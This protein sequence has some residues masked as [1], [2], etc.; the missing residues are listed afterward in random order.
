MKNS[1][2]IKRTAKRQ[3]PL[4]RPWLVDLEELIPDLEKVWASGKLSLGLYTEKLEAYARKTLGV[5]EAIA[6]SSCTSGIILVLKALEIK[7]KVIVPD[8]TFPATSHAVLWAGAKVKFC[9]ID[10]DD[11]TISPEALAEINDPEVEAVIPVNI[12]GLPPKISELEKICAKRGWKLIFDSAQGLGAE[13]KG[14]RCGGFGIAEVFSLSPSKVITSAE[15]GIITTNDSGLALKLR[16]LRDYGKG[17]DKADML[18]VGLSARMSEL[19]AVLG[20]HNFKHLDKLRLEREKLVKRYRKKL[21]GIKGLAFQEFGPER[22]SGYNYFVFRVT[23]EAGKTRDHLLEELIQA[24]IECKRYFYPPL[25]LLTAYKGLSNGG[26][27]NAELLSWETI[28]V[29]LY[30]GMK[31]QEQDQVI[32]EI[33][34]IING[35]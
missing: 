25:H 14:K 7:K 13:Y 11:F 12:F 16:Q 29:P 35:K 28:A 21:S 17:P 9:D 23:A 34:I 2:A 32:R 26:F 10:M 8:Y 31:T 1:H 33:G 19:C 5:K 20:C 30:S 6:V 4:L 24:G 27:K 18:G 3:I 15:G 22:K